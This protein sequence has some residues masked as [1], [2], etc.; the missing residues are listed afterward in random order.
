MQDYLD[1][2]GMVIDYS[3]PREVIFDMQDYVTKMIADFE[4]VAGEIKTAKTPAADHLFQVR[5]EATALGEK[6]SLLFHNMTAKALYLCKRSRPDI[7]TAVSFLTTRV[8]DP[9]Q[10]DWKKLVRLLR[11]LK[12]SKTLVLT[13][14]DDGKGLKW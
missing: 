11:Y 7:Q 5:E 9:D 14:S 12:G 4:A 2:L 1:Y 8:K 10:D 6:E 3:V 13:L